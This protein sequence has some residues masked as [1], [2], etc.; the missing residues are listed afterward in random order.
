MI[1]G[2][3]LSI[4]LSVLA[5]SISFFLYKQWKNMNEIE[6]T[7]EKGTEGELSDKELRIRKCVADISVFINE[8]TQAFINAELGI[9]IGFVLTFGLVILMLTG[10]RGRKDYLQ[11]PIGNAIVSFEQD[12]VFGI[13]SA[14]A[15]I[16]GAATSALAGYIGIVAASTANGRVAHKISDRRDRDRRAG[17]QKGF[18]TCLRGG[19]VMSFGMFTVGIINLFVLASLYVLHYDTCK[20]PT[21]CRQK[22]IAYCILSYGVGASSI[23]ILHRIGGSI[24]MK[25]IDLCTIMLGKG[26]GVLHLD[27]VDD[28]LTS[29][30][31]PNREAHAILHAIDLPRFDARQ[32]ATIADSVGDIIG[33]VAGAGADYFGSFSQA[34]CASLAILASSVNTLEKDQTTPVINHWAIVCLPLMLFETGIVI[35]ILLYLLTVS[36]SSPFNPKITARTSGDED[37]VT[38]Q[39]GHRPS[40]KHIKDNITNALWNQVMAA[41]LITAFI[42]FFMCIFMLPDE[43]YVDFWLHMGTHETSNLLVKDWELGLCVSIGSLM[44]LIGAYIGM[45][46]TS[47]GGTPVRETAEACT[48]D[49]T[50]QQ[51]QLEQSQLPDQEKREIITS[52][53]IY[54]MNAGDVT[55]VGLIFGGK[56]TLA[57]VLNLVV[58]IYTVHYIA[59]GMG[60]AFAAMGCMASVC[61]MLIVT[62]FGPIAKNANVMAE[63]SGMDEVSRE[64]AGHLSMAGANMLAMSK[65][66]STTASCLCASAMVSAYALRADVQRQNVSI[67]EPVCLS[68]LLVGGMTI[69][70]LCGMVHEATMKTATLVQEHIKKEFQDNGERIMDGDVRPNYKECIAQATSESLKNL[71]PIGLMIVMTP[72][73]VGLLFGRAACTGVVIGCIMVGVPQA[74]SSAIAGGIW[75]VTRQHLQD[76]F[77]GPTQGYDKYKAMLVQEEVFRMQQR[78]DDP[79]CDFSEDDE[80]GESYE[81]IKQKVKEMK[82]QEP[83]ENAEENENAG[84]ILKDAIAPSINILMKEMAILTAVLGSYFASVRGGYGILGCNFSHNCDSDRY[85][86]EGFDIMVLVLYSILIGFIIV[87]RSCKYYFSV[88]DTPPPQ[89]EATQHLLSKQQTYGSSDLDAN[90]EYKD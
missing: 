72:L 90:A 74:C 55:I 14:I 89:D 70:R 6:V 66:F 68:G 9:M 52:G 42:N 84:E 69:Y 75:A 85:P 22:A 20:G 28:S 41:A 62:T 48:R 1:D 54:R 5:V 47:E 73:S 51:S 39:P 81:E 64:G 35:S 45:R 43:M 7:P 79:D 33:D 49:L 71:I 24:Y 26:G 2:V 82:P 80:D 29:R 59:H 38:N 76:A 25:A 12:W 3:W 40:N 63:M 67:F 46:Y 78:M 56:A 58:G 77:Y 87:Y 11:S 10:S 50:Y 17:V 44:G 32:P 61:T 31:D 37:S 60:I 27:D 16:C 65:N 88:E 19:A 53:M 86:M 34:I 23:S 13:F 21:S 15:F 36:K 8:G 83:Y 57:T 30:S 4:L 18:E